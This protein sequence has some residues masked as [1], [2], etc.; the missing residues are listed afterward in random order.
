MSFHSSYYKTDKVFDTY[1]ENLK[2][3]VYRFAKK[4]LNNHDDA[5]DVMQ[6]VFE[7]LWKMRKDL[8]KFDS[9]DAFTIRMTKNL[10][11]DRLKHEKVKQTKL[12]FIEDRS[13]IRKEHEYVNT[14]TSEIIKD[15]INRLPQ[16]QKMIL[17]LRDV[18]GCEFNKISEIMDMEIGTVRMNLSRGR[19]V[20]KEQL[21]K[22]MSYGLQRSEKISRQV[23]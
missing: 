5:Q 1:V 13:D 9:V 17:H 10:C 6:D 7:R 16:K 14:E 20:V 18:E 23:F 11:L 15:L 8:N 22:I 2:D 21:I 3:K 19:K 4:I 12:K